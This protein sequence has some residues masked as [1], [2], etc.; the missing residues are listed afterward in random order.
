MIDELAELI[1]KEGLKVGA[2]D[3]AG[4]VRRSQKRM[5]RF[6]NNKV[7]VSKEWEEVEAYFYLGYKRRALTGSLNKVDEHT[8]RRSFADLVKV[9]TYAEPLEDYVPLPK[10]PFNYGTLEEAFDERIAKLE[11]LTGYVEEAIDSALSEGAKRVA[12][13]LNVCVEEKFLATSSGIKAK[14]RGTG[15]SITV[16][17]FL[18]GEDSGQGVSC[19]R[20]LNK[21]N[22]SLAG[23][24]A[25]EIASMCKER[26]SIAAGRYDV[27]LDPLVVANLMSYVVYFGLSAYFVEANLSFFTGQIGKNVAS[28][29]VTITDDGRLPNGPRSTLFDDEGIPTGKTVLIEGGVLK[30]LLHNSRTAKKFGAKPTGNAGWITPRPWN[31]VVEPGNYHDEEII[32]ELKRGVYITNNWYTRFQNLREGVFSTITRDGVFLVEGGE[33]K[34]A[35]KGVRISDKFGN[36]LRNVEA[37]S[38][39]RELIEWWET[40]APTLAPRI[41]VKDL[42]LTKA[43]K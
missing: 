36:L 10:G 35:V 24:K 7:T 42:N 19:S 4:L 39:E 12:G 17:A 27:V 18:D 22:P 33:V 9:A 6:S 20:V 16:R 40:L 11:D 5:V 26:A 21:F 37:L 28:G 13:V 2:E 15:M 29:K 34:G 25:G 43:T 38:R 30:G 23:S 14:D 32:E 8:I 3:V 31:V 1:V 41:L